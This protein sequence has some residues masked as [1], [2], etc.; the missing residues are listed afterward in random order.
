M[1]DLSAI[2]ATGYGRKNIPFA[3]F[4]MSEISC[5]GLGAHWCAHWCAPCV[6]GGV[7]RIPAFKSAL[8]RHIAL[9]IVQT[10]YN[11][12]LAAAYGAALLAAGNAL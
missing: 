8:E 11:P 6:T 10:D 4:N 3:Q 1:N 5:H 2:C 7:A 9:P 12:Q